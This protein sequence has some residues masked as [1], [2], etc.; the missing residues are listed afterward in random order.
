MS[1]QQHTPEPWSIRCHTCATPSD[2]SAGDDYTIEGADS[3]PIGFEPQRRNQRVGV[4]ARR[5]VACVNACVGIKTADLE[6]M[7]GTSILAKANES[8]DRV[9]KQR[10]ELL[11][12]AEEVSCSGDTRLASMAIATI[13]S[14]KGILK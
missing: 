6:A 10:D 1:N 8:C 12:F 3:T 9:Q 5:I 4:D 7:R 13:V 14:V 11:A 2:I